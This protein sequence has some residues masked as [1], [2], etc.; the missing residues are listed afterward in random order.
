LA[1][2]SIITPAGAQVQVQTHVD[3]INGTLLA[4]RVASDDAATHEAVMPGLSALRRWTTPTPWP[5]R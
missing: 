1:T 2:F 5:P 3:L 4:Q